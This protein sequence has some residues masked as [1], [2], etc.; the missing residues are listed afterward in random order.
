[1]HKILAFVRESRGLNGPKT[2]PIIPWIWD[3][4]L[5]SGLSR[6]QFQRPVFCCSENGEY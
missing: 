1:M 5:F 3:C 4:I 2:E 6:V